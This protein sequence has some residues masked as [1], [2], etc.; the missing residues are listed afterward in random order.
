MSNRTDEA[1]NAS[2]ASLARIR[3]L[4]RVAIP[5]ALVALGIIL[6][7]YGITFYVL[8]PD[9]RFL[10]PP[11]HGVIQEGILDGEVLAEIMGGPV[12]DRHGRRARPG[13]RLRAG[14]LRWPW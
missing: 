4:V 10:L 5:P 2:R 6:L 7:W 14:V 8:E 3:E 13:H 11:P 1:T 9:R 12:P